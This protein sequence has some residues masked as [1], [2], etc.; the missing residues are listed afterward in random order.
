MDRAGLLAKIKQIELRSRKRL[1]SKMLG[2]FQTTIRGTGLIFDAVRPYESGDNV[3]DI[4][5]NVTARTGELHI[6]Q[7]IEDR[8]YQ[9]MLLVDRSASMGISTTPTKRV[10]VVAEVAATIAWSAILNQDAVGMITFA[11]KTIEVLK[12]NSQ[13]IQL[14]YILKHLLQDTLQSSPKTSLNSVINT[15][16]EL[17]RFP[18]LIFILSDFQFDLTDSHDLLKYLSRL[19][20]VVAIKFSDPLELHPIP[21]TAL[22]QVRDSESGSYK[23]VDTTHPIY[24]RSITRSENDSFFQS[25]G[26]DLLTL[27]L[28]EDYITHFLKFIQSRSERTKP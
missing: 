6:K 25:I 5:W 11:E 21:K 28:D 10:D 8:Q 18:S 19:H 3:R 9:V 13:Q 23:Q 20:D 2:N 24:R 26:I 17:V 7:Y 14:D 16:I 12:P 15:F 1:T 4:D 27:A 22:I